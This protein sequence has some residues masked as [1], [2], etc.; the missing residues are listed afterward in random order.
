MPIIPT[1]KRK[2]NYSKL[3]TSLIYRATYMHACRHERTHA[4]KKVLTLL[5]ETKGREREEKKEGGRFFLCT[6]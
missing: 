5:G 1:L 6:C 4:C 3:E 2:K